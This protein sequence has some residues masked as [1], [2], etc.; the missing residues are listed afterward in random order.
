MKLPAGPGWC[1]DVVHGRTRTYRCRSGE[2]IRPSTPAARVLPDT[3]VPRAT[4]ALHPPRVQDPAHPAPR[5]GSKPARAPS[6]RVQTLDNNCGFLRWCGLFIYFFF[7]P[8][9]FLPKGAN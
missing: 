7:F 3:R 1:S 8:S 5:A 9:G 4:A 6:V 2:R